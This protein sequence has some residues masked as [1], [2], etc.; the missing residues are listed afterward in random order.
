MG[1]LSKFLS[2]LSGNND[3]KVSE[4]LLFDKVIGFRGIVPGC[5]TSTIVQNVAIALSEKTKYTV[6]VL[7]TNFMYPIQY[8]LLVKA[9]D[10]NK[11]LDILDYTKDI[12]K[13]TMATDYN[14]VY[15]VRLNNRNIIDMLS[16]KD[17]DAILNKLISALKSYF[18]IVLVDISTEYTNI[19]V[20]AAIKC[21][22]IYQV[23]DTSLKSLYNIKKSLNTMVTLAVPLAKAYNV[24][25]N[26]DLPNILLGTNSALEEAGLHLVGTIPLSVDIASYCASGKKIYGATTINKEITAF[27]RVIDRL[28]D[29]IAIKTPRNVKYFDVGKALDEKNKERAL[30]ESNGDDLIDT[31]GDDV[32]VDLIDSYEEELEGETK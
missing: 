32:L 17:N 13:I 4:Q 18:D 25:L 2:A 26:K 31:I 19:S 30:R 12:S 20:N 1:I 3:L 27:N 23:A 6:C 8:P 9:E 29:D 28:V 5:G 7:D 24:I 11:H 14:N 10:D 22:K 15:L 21:N 16:G